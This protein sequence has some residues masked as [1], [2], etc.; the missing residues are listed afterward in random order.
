MIERRYIEEFKNINS[1]LILVVLVKVINTNNIET[2]NFV[3]LLL[4]VYH[5]MNRQYGNDD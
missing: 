5:S 3:T 2:N 4:K 1:S